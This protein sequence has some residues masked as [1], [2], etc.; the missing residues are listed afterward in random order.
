MLA[1]VLL[2]GL[3]TVSMKFS[4]AVCVLAV[5]GTLPV[6]W[7]LAPETTAG[8]VTTRLP[9]GLVGSGGGVDENA[10]A[11]AAPGASSARQSS[12]LTTR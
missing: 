7:K 4:P 12:S 11:H 9:T 5:I 2:D 8:I 1:V 10:S 3:A 6:G